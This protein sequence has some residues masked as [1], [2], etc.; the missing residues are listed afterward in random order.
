MVELVGDLDI[1]TADALRAAL[2]TASRGVPAR[3]LLVVDLDGVQFCGARGLD[4]LIEAAETGP[5]LVLARCSAP[6][7]RLLD[8]LQVTHEPHP[9]PHD[10]SAVA[11]APHRTG[12]ERSGAERSGT[13]QDRRD[14][15]CGTTVARHRHPAREARPW[16][17][18]PP[19]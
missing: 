16:R 3:G 19:P 13:G 1:A 14:P 5:R 7:R 11:I 2:L 9:L 4:V 12:A 10:P 15:T 18:I 6:V 17:S 8:L